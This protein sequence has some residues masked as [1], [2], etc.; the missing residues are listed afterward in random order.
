VKD[1]LGFA[2]GYLFRTVEESISRLA[3]IEG[4]KESDLTSE[5]AEML[6]RSLP[7]KP[8][9][10]KL[11][12][13]DPFP[14]KRTAKKAKIKR[15]PIVQAVCRKC[16][17]TA[18]NRAEIT[19]HYNLEHRTYPKGGWGLGKKGATKKRIQLVA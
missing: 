4:L 7:P 9:K 13:A 6:S 1:K 15:G 19:R 8:A 5:L 10:R 18:P 11:E 12:T 16:G 3:G 14:V 2:V 17:F